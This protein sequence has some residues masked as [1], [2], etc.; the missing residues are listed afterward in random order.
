MLLHFSLIS[1]SAWYKYFIKFKVLLFFCVFEKRFDFNYVV[2]FPQ[3][4]LLEI[5]ALSFLFLKID[6]SFCSFRVKEAKNVA[7]EV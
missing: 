5:V 7:Q 3:I 4:L 1:F 6:K 2:H